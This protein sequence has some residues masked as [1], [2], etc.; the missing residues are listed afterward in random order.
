[1]TSEIINFLED[2]LEHQMA[3]EDTLSTDISAEV[4][5]E[6]VDQ[7]DLDFQDQ[8]LDLFFVPQVPREEVVFKCK[9]CARMFASRYAFTLHVNTHQKRCLNCRVVYQTWKEVEKHEQFCPST[10]AS[11]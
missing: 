6:P 9:I 1:M 4:K 11:K 7:W 2:E 10:L 8:P 3:V 5:A